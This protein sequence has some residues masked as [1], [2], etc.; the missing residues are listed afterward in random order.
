[1]RSD[2]TAYGGNRGARA[3]VARLCDRGVRVARWGSPRRVRTVGR[4]AVS[5]YDLLKRVCRRRAAVLI[6]EFSAARV[7]FFFFFFLCL[8]SS[9]C[10]LTISRNRV[11]MNELIIGRRCYRENNKMIRGGYEY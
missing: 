5:F 6:R 10:S 8:L 9:A 2:F 3:T 11:E 7:N 1:M 4:F